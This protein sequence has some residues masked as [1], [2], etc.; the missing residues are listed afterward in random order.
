MV[1]EFGSMQG[2]AGRYYAAHDG[3]PADVPVAIQEQYK[4]LFAGDTLPETATGQAVSLADKL[5]TLMGIWAAGQQPTG[6]KDPFALRRAAL[7]VLRIII[8]GGLALDLRELLEQAA[9]AYA[10]EIG[11]SEKVQE[12]YDFAMD[13][14]RPYF[15][16]QDYTPQQFDAVLAVSPASPLDFSKRISA[17][18]KFSTMKQA[19]SLSAANKRIRNIL[20]KVEGNVADSVDRKLFQETQETSLFG[21]IATQKMAAKPLLETGEYDKVLANLATLK[22]TVDAFFDGVMVM[23]EDEALKNNRIALLAQ[24]RAMFLQV[25]DL[26]QLQN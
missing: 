25:A 19:D 2:I 18:K 16:D 17:V 23:A 20:K 14:L 24:L 5:D 26:S 1:L 12:V 13:R 11:A 4:P 10:D 22:D 7:G 9:S 8:E 15:V 3:E 21:A 6:A